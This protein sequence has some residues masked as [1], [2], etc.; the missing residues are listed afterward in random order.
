MSEFSNF[1]KETENNNRLGEKLIDR[2]R[3]VFY[4][5]KVIPAK[6]RISEEDTRAIVVV[7]KLVDDKEK[8]VVVYSDDAEIDLYVLDNSLIL[9]VSVTPGSVSASE[10]PLPHIEVEIYDP[11]DDEVD[12]RARPKYEGHEF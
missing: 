10:T 6:V 3:V 8:A 11:A 2:S 12:G 1:E 7:G 9:P 4:E 5:E